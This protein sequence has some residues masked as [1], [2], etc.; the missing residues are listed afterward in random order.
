M[1]YFFLKL[2]VLFFGMATKLLAHKHL[3]FGSNCL[4]KGTVTYLFWHK[5]AMK[6]L[7]RHAG[8]HEL[9]KFEN[10]WANYEGSLIFLEEKQ[11]CSSCLR[12]FAFAV[13]SIITS[14][15]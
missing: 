11:T 15:V 14:Y 12:T 5:G 13:E 1:K 10:F 3:L 9:R 6:K 8:C 7:L 4:M 2:C